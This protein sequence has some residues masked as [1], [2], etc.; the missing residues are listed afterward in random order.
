MERLQSLSTVLSTLS[1]IPTHFE[2]AS[3][4]DQQCLSDIVH[5]IIIRHVNSLGMNEQEL[6]AI[7]AVLLADVNDSENIT[8]PLVS[9]ANPRIASTLDAMRDL[10]KLLKDAGQW[11]VY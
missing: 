5:N 8:I 2:M 9:D 11:T 1:H 7:L 4:G 10:F 3:F 6:P